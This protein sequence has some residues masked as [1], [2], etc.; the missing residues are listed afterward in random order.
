M[1]KLIPSLVLVVVLLCAA[2][3]WS[4]DTE[5]T[6]QEIEN[7]AKELV[8]KL[9]QPN[10]NEREAAS[11]ELVKLGLGALQVIEAG[12]KNPDPEIRTRCVSLYQ[13]IRDL[14]LKRRIE[15]LAD[16]QDGRIANTLPLCATYVKICGKDENARQ[17]YFE[18]CKNNM[19]LLEYA[20]NNPKFT[21][22]AFNDLTKEIEKSGKG[23][24]SPELEGAALLLIAADEKIGPSILE[25]NRQQ[26]KGGDR[27]Y[28]RFIGLLWTP[29]YEAV[30]IDPNSGRYFRKLL[31]AWAKRLN[32]PLAM[33]SFLFFIQD[34]INK[35]IMNLNSDSDT[36]EFLMDFA[37]SRTSR[38]LPYQK[39]TAMALVAASSLS[40]KD[41]VAYFE[42]KL[43]QDETTLQ[44]S[45]GFD[46]NGA[47]KITV[48]TRACDYSLAVCVKLS[49]QSFNDYG[50]DI[51]GPRS[52]VFGSWMNSG[53]TKDETRQA[54]IK[55][56]LEWRTANPLK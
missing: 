17:F 19:E 36:L 25:A 22:E 54:A 21:G 6:P 47:T 5:K 14:E 30:M 4:A 10:F 32:E 8:V 34:M 3:V 42:E 1:K 16:D 53:F 20:A 15:E 29:K 13:T 23:A 27:N 24:F 38:G 9:G 39:G 2:T 41:K 55:K 40:Q 43:L 35:Q 28:Q 12:R 11:Q 37:A 26:L 56:Y 7:L 44:P 33:Q 48:E 50:F 49:G 52:D 31:F 46:L 51:L 45:V 18:L